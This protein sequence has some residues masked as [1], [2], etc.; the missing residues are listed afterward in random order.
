MS[1]FARRVQRLLW[2]PYQEHSQKAQCLLFLQNLQRCY[3]C[4]EIM[5]VATKY[6]RNLVNQH[7]DERLRWLLAPLQG[8]LQDRVTWSM[9]FLPLEEEE[10]AHGPSTL[11]CLAQFSCSEEAC[12][13]MVWQNERMMKKKLLLQ[14]WEARQRPLEI[15]NEILSVSLSGDFFYAFGYFPS[16]AGQ[17]IHIYAVKRMHIYIYICI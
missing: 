16:V 6:F 3:R 13:T 5:L 14:Y 8:T 10:D 12:F 4:T 11:K 1:R 7:S 15:A 2:P 17:R 9:P